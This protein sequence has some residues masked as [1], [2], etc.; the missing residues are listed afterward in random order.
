M[1]QHQLDTATDSPAEGQSQESTAT[2]TFT[3]DE[4]DKIVAD[5]IARERGKY[6]KKYAGIDLD[7]YNQL[8]A[9]EEQRKLEEQ[10]ARGEFEQILKTTVE[11]KD[12]VIRQLQSELQTVLVDGQLLNAASANRVVN[13]QQVVRLLKDQV[14]LGE[15]GTVEVIDPQ[16]G[17]L[18]YSESGDPYK[19]A[20]LMSDFLR[21]NPHFVAAAA[22]GSGTRSN[23]N[24]NKPNKEIDIS[25]LDMKNPEHRKIY[26]EY[27]KQNGIA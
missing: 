20:D 15:T 10:K 12:T 17:Q 11:K 26:A 3:Q 14:R 8:T 2:K 16:S 9:A 13:P 22:P 24:A 27:R 18:K 6:E 7:K 5:R 4:L 1:E 21:E 25:K 19:I 23:A